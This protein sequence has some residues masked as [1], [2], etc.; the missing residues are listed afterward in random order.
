MSKWN[1]ICCRK[2]W[3]KQNPFQPCVEVDGDEQELCC[4]CGEPTRVVIWVRYNPSEIDCEHTKAAA[5]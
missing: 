2:C 5:S 1:Q 4:F 3:N